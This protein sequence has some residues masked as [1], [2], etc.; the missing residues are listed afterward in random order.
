MSR[1]VVLG[2]PIDALTFQEALARFRMFLTD[3]KQHHIATPNPEMLIEAQR[4]PLFHRVLQETSLNLA[5]GTGLLW[6]SRLK[7][8]PLPERVTGTDMMKAL[9]MEKDLP[10]VFLLGAAFGIAEKVGEILRGQNPSLVIAGTWS[11]FPDE[12]QEG[13]IVHRINASGAHI[14]FVAFGAPK[15]ELWIHRNLTKLP[16]VHLAMGVGGAFDFIAG[17]QKR[18]PVWMQSLG[19]EWLYRLMKEPRRVKR[20]W[21]AVVVFPIL[22][23]KRTNIKESKNQTI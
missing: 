6:A 2:V 14:L 22:V 3:E 23:M 7:G 8:H 10:P 18:A 19:L 1:P 17:K 12:E 5:D 20:I 16:S 11:G 21:N 13:D 9:C 15:Q 4:N